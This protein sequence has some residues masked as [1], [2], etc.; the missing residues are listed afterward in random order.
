MRERRAGGHGRR[1]R[2]EGH[3]LLPGG[4]GGWPAVPVGSSTCRRGQAGRPS[5]GRALRRRG[6]SGLVAH[7]GL[8]RLRSRVRRRGARDRCGAGRHGRGAFRRVSGTRHA[9]TALR[10]P[11]G[12]DDERR[13]PG[14]RIRGRRP[15]ERTGNGDAARDRDPTAG[16]GLARECGCRKSHRSGW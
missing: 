3:R 1:R 6:Q 14:H 2:D 12:R 9:A 7:R 16:R 8:G 4:P 10:A 11:P 15:R 13:G 5:E